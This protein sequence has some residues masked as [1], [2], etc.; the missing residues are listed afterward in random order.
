M[1]IKKIIKYGI[2]FMLVLLCIVFIINFY[3]VK[4]TK[5][6]IITSD[7]ISDLKDIDC[8]LV[9]GAGIWG[10]KPSPMLE[11]RLNEA[12][13]LYKQNVSAK[14]IMSG[15]HGR[16][17]YD[18]V[19]IMKDYAIEKGV[20]SEA[21]FMDHAGF[22]SYESIYRLREIFE[23][24]KVVIVTQKYHL[25]R[26]LYIANQFDLEAYGVNSDPRRYVGAAYRELREVL[27]R[28]KDFIQCIIKP[29]PTY[30]GETIPVSGNGDITNDKENAVQEN[31]IKDL[32]SVSGIIEKIDNNK[33]SVYCDGKVYEID[34]SE[35]FI[36]MRT[37][38]KISLKEINVYDYY[39][40]SGEIA[41]NISGN[42][43]K[44]ELLKN[45]AKCFS[46]GPLYAKPI[47]ITNLEDKGEYVIID[48][49][50]EDALSGKLGRQF[51]ARVDMKLKVNNKT[52]ISTVQKI[53]IK[54]LKEETNGFMFWIEIVEDTIDD[55]YP[56]V[57]TIE[58]YDK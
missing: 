45:M 51:D 34:Y 4:T 38:E 12:I 41:R 33:L 7:K 39:E 55:E 21:I 17:E 19:N 43:L 54:D 56:T 37:R 3:V 57:K 31:E 11:D 47:Q 23:A 53:D 28:N 27:A 6:Q 32:K 29:K 36:N 46:S 14:I 2:I 50:M 40:S 26:A 44:Q 58:I 9:L 8:I 42:E 15:D 16:E 52:N 18:E 1:K 5:N 48:V 10:D 49:T 20:P 22:S 24:K 35:E 13:S 30:L 25:F